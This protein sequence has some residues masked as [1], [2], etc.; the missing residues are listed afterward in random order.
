MLT[1]CSNVQ[2][3]TEDRLPALGPNQGIAA[4][5][6]TH[7][8]DVFAV[9]I[10]PIS[11]TGKTLEIP[12]LPDGESVFLF[13]TEAGRYCLDHFSSGAGSYY[14]AK[15][16]QCFDVEV[17]KIAYGGMYQPLPGLTILNGSVP[18]EGLGHGAVMVDVDDW[19]G[20]LRLMRAKYPHIAASAF[21]TKSDVSLAQEKLPPPPATPPPSGV[22]DLMTTEQA[23]EL[24]GKEVKPGVEWKFGNLTTC[25]YQHSDDESVHVHFE[26]CSDPNEDLDSSFGKESF[27][28]GG[29]M[30]PIQGFPGKAGI[31]NKG[32][33]YELNVALPDRM[34]ILIVDGTKREDIVEAMVAAMQRILPNVKPLPPQPCA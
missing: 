23:S 1:A 4:I 9:R 29:V 6:F 8:S 28:T 21:A 10:K 11:G 19:P 31:A 22:C 25:N 18:P 32:H 7:A 26:P 2:P 33:N 16:D 17:G 3:Y 20:F 24:L 30:Q 34:I 12:S 27:A 14:S 13:V 15:D 5:A